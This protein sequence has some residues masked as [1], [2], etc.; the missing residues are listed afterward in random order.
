MRE[1]R[2]TNHKCRDGG[3]GMNRRERRMWWLR[4]HRGAGREIASEGR[5]TPIEPHANSVG[6]LHIAELVLHGFPPAAAHAIGDV[7]QIELTKM[8]GSTKAP[9][10]FQ[11]DATRLRGPTFQVPSNAPS[12]TIGRLIANAIH[13]GSK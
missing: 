12:R 3:L 1:D 9:A 5:A 8:L 6:T 2:K 13:G 10:H 4:A 7:T 11:R